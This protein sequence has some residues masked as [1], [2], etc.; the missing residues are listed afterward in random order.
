[1]NERILELAEKAFD[2]ANE[3][4]LKRME[5]TVENMASEINMLNPLIKIK[6]SDLENKIYDFQYKLDVLL[7]LHSHGKLFSGQTTT[8]I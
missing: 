5:T 1:M 7:S 8:V 3:E 2:L 6:I 4:I